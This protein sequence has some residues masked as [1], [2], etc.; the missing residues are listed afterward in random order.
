MVPVDLGQMQ[1]LKEE[2][3]VTWKH[4][5]EGDFVVTKSPLPFCNPFTHQA[6]EKEIKGLKRFGALPGL[7]Q[8]YSTTHN[9]NR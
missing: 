6:L 5:V 7:N 4:L 1:E 9:Q 3:P 2:D 8:D